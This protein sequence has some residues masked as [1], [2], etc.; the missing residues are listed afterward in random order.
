MVQSQT[1]L[2]T[3]F[4]HD[5]LFYYIPGLKRNI[6]PSLDEEIRKNNNLMKIIKTKFLFDFVKIG[7]LRLLANLTLF[8][9]PIFLDL[10]TNNLKDF[11]NGKEEKDELKFCN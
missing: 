5:F 9:G 11:G 10:L 4:L 3:S 8:T 6:F 1:N 2:K 7:I